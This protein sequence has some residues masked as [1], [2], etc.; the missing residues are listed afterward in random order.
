MHTDILT[1][2]EL[3]EYLKLS[4]AKVYQM[5]QRGELPSTKL[6]THWR[7]RK[8]L[9]DRWLEEQMTRNP[10]GLNTDS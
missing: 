4:R 3:A 10:Q 9:I 6:G 8:D 7:F 2:S 5:A 1:V